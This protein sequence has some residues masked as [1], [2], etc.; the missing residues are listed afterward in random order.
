MESNLMDE[1]IKEVYDF[2][3]KAQEREIDLIKNR[4]EFIN[5]LFGVAS[6]LLFA[7]VL[8]ARTITPDPCPEIAPENYIALS[9]GIFSFLAI[10]CTF[11]G[12]WKGYNS[13][14]NRITILTLLDIQKSAFLKETPPTGS[15]DDKAVKFT[16]FEY[17]PKEQK[18]K[19][20]YCSKF[21]ERKHSEIFWLI[22]LSVCVFISLASML[23]L[24]AELTI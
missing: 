3:V 13:V 14:G 23:V 5:W 12:K 1:I 24:L 19:Y 15:S 6:A 7:S 11:L 2:S 8:A 17:L 21:G 9:A 18:D 10:I 22:S 20:D 4:L 16:M